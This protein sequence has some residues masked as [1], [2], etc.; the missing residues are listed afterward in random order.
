[1]SWPTYHDRHW[2]LG[3]WQLPGVTRVLKAAGLGVDYTGVDPDVLEHARQR[4]VYVDAACDA[5]DTNTPLPPPATPEQAEAR[6]RAAGYVTA[7]RDYRAATG[8]TPRYAQGVLY[9][10]ELRYLGIPDSADAVTVI[11]R[12]ATAKIART[13]ALQLAAYTLDGLYAR[14]PDGTWQ[15]WTATQRRVVHLKKDGT[16]GVRDYDDPTDFAVWTAAATVA[17]HAPRYQKG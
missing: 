12:K 4:G 14:Q 10:P 9:H 17:L 7:W 13:Y 1:M 2:W 6:A 5:L 15:P 8:W 3:D 11:D 16:Y